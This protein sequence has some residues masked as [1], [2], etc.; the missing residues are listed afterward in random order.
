MVGS[1]RVWGDDVT[2]AVTSLSVGGHGVG[3][4]GDP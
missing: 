2:S 4:L 1:S 3:V